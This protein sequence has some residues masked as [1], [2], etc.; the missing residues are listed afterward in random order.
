[1][2]YRIAAQPKAPQE[3]EAW[4]VK[5]PHRFISDGPIDPRTAHDNGGDC[6]PI[7]L[8]ATPGPSMTERLLAGSRSCYA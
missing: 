1:M 2:K 6:P 4:L 3:P 5:F 7:Q 8:R